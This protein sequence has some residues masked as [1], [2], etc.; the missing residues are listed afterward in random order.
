MGKARKTS[1]QRLA[2]SF[3]SLHSGAS[4]ADIS[5]YPKRD[6]AHYHWISPGP[7]KAEEGLEVRCL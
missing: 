4:E 5:L 6:L 1:W 2:Y 3:T 7:G